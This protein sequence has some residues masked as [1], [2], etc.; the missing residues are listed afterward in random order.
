VR[1]RVGLRA[2]GR[3][4]ACL[5]ALEARDPA[6]FQHELRRR[7]RRS[8]GRLRAFWLSVLRESALRSS[9]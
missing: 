4:R 3:Q 1:G 9:A 2:L 8:R 5:I 6:A 7:L